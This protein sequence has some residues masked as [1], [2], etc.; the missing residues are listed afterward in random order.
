ME[1]QF[2]RFAATSKRSKR[3]ASPSSKKIAGAESGGELHSPIESQRLPPVCCQG[4]R[5]AHPLA[6]RRP[7]MVAGAFI[8]PEASVRELHP[9]VTKA[10]GT[11]REGSHPVCQTSHLRKAQLSG[12]HRDCESWVIPL[13]RQPTSSSDVACSERRIA[14]PSATQ[15]S[16]ASS[17]SAMRRPADRRRLRRRPG[18]AQTGSSTNLILFVASHVPPLIASSERHRC[19]L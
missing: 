3:R 6:A 5:P 11:L 19:G 15:T 13:R 2:A 8:A 17:F 4:K 18:S 1:P 12:A 7:R 10:S 9:E 14:P 16:R